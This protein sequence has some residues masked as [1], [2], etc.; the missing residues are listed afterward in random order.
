MSEQW[1]TALIRH[2]REGRVAY[3]GGERQHTGG[4]ERHT[5]LYLALVAIV[6][7]QLQQVK[8]RHTLIS[9]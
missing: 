8:E 9:T 4:G 5:A 2:T 1:T 3:T 6:V 7:L